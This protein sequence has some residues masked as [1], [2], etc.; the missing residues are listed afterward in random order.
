MMPKILIK[1][2]DRLVVQVTTESA[3]FE[4]APGKT[5][6]F[7]GNEFKL[8]TVKPEPPADEHSADEAK[9]G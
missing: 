8:K 9:N 6:T 2:T 1:N 3:M 5:R 4:I 7:Y